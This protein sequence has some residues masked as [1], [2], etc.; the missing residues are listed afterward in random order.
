MTRYFKLKTLKKNTRLSLGIAS[1]LAA[2]MRVMIERCGAH[3]PR[4]GGTYVY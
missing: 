3:A 2:G 4:N 1:E